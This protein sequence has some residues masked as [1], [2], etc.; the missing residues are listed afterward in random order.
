MA[1]ERDPYWQMLWSAAFALA[2]RG[3]QEG[4]PTASLCSLFSREIV[5][6]LVH[7]A[8]KNRVFQTL[9]LRP[10]VGSISH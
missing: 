9:V 1:G 6:G 2:A 10:I 7:W 3:S 4:M 5:L 8:W